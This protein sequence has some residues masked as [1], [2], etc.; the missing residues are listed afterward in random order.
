MFAGWYEPARA[1]IEATPD[2]MLIRQDINDLEPI[3]EW[4]RGRVALLG[5]AAHATTPILGQ[6]GCGAIEDGV[7]LARK[8]GRNGDV[9]SALREYVAERKV[10]ANGIIRQARRHGAIYHA[11]NPVFAVARGV[12]MRGPV[13][14]AMREVDK[15][16][17]YKA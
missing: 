14:I 6:G 1:V 5:D 9:A 7:V 10:R 16:I 4:S 12:M 11:V 17:G 2:D 3:E 13:P 8:L 15:L